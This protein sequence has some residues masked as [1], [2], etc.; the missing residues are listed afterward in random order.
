M[1]NSTKIRSAGP[2]DADDAAPA[3]H[4]SVTR[5]EWH[6]AKDKEPETAT[7]PCDAHSHEKCMCEGAC[8]CHWRKL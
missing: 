4:R 1:A 7:H 5:L 3:G 6:A 8:S 2:A